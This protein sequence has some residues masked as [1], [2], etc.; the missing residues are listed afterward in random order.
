MDKL[1]VLERH[2]QFK[3]VSVK[4][5]E[6]L[7]DIRRYLLKFLKHSKKPLPSFTEEDIVRFLNSLKYSIR[8]INDIKAFIKV[9]VKWNYP[10]WSSKFRNLEK[11]CRGQKPSK[12]YQPEQMISFEEFERIVKAENNLMW[13]TYWLVFFYGGFRPS[14]ACRL[15][16]SDILFEEEGVIIKLHTKK[17]NKD[18]YKSLPENASQMLNEL[19]AQSSS[20]F[21]FP[22]PLKK[23]ECIKPRTACL[24]LKRLSLKTLGKDVVPYAMR[25]SIATL[26]YKDDKRKDDDSANQMGH[27]KSMKAVYMNLDE[28]ELKRKA[29]NLWIQTETLPKEI[30][31]EYEKRIKQLEEAVKKIETNKNTLLNGIFEK[32]LEEAMQVWV[33][34]GKIRLM[35]ELKTK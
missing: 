9:F 29:R 27:T 1:H 10:D 34:K 7:K 13:K 3:R 28:H 32:K 26:L 24:R 17:T 21:L 33:K 2:I 15:K 12:A 20:E 14:E 23:S 31:K 25:H 4:S 6:K 16:W 11:I 5:E 18:F 35:E 30:K 22:S 19:K 8:T